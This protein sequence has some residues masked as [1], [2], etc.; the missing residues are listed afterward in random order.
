MSINEENVDM[1]FKP[2][3]PYNELRPLWV[4]ALRLSAA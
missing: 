3:R 4:Y 1:S 2:D